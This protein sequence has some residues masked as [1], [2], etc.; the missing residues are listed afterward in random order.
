MK[1]EVE[2]FS[3]MRGPMIGGGGGGGDQ[4]FFMKKNA[5]KPK[6]KDEISSNLYSA[7]KMTSQALSKKKK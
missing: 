3:K 5:A 6:F 4:E 2:S 1:S 7:S